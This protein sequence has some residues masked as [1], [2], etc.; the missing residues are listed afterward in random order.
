MKKILLV[1]LTFMCLFTLVACKNDTSSN[2]EEKVAEETL[3]VQEE[4]TNEEEEKVYEKDE[5]PDFSIVVCGKTITKEEMDEYAVYTISVQTTNSEGTVKDYTYA[6]Y[7]ILDVLKAAG[8]KTSEGV[9]VATA[10]DGYEINYEEN[11][12]I[13][14]TLI[15]LI[16]N[17]ETFKEGPW[18]APCESTTNGDYLK[19]LSEIKIA[20]Q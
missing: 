15:A 16:R 8:V 11:I 7:S 6:G 2:Q 4:T 18:L 14:P 9:V 1:L 20:V 5:M 13:E 12:I 10:T 19:N 3:E 17:D